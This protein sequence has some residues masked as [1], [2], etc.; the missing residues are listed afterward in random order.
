MKI[1]NNKSNYN[2]SRN[3]NNFNKWIKLNKILSKK[4]YNKVMSKIKIIYHKEIKANQEFLEI[5]III[6]KDWLNK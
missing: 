2:N 3:K 6:K 1:C 5:Q 4:N